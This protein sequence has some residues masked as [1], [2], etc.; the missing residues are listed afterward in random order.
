LGSP[1]APASEISTCGE[2]E[3][4]LAEDRQAPVKQA[5][6]SSAELR[7]DRRDRA[8][9]ASPVAPR[10]TV[11]PICWSMCTIDVPM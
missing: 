10:Q 4:V 2:R 9:R 3:P 11:S 1:Q 5:Q 7:F 6:L 8:F